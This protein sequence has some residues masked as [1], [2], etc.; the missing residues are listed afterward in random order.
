MALRI[1]A[2]SNSNT[3]EHS[4]DI[5]EIQR[6]IHVPLEEAVE[7]WLHFVGYDERIVSGESRFSLFVHVRSWSTFHQDCLRWIECTLYYYA[8]QFG[9]TYTSISV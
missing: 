5:L 6:G 4:T 9:S 8:S 7:E 1:G 2:F 3:R